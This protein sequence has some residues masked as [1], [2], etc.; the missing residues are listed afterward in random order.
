MVYPGPGGTELVLAQICTE[1]FPTQLH[2]HG[3]T[4]VILAAQY[5]MPLLVLPIV[6]ANILLF[7]R[8]NSGFQTDQRRREREL[9]RTRRMT[10]ILTLIGFI[11]AVS[12]LPF[13][14][15]VILTDVFFLFQD[16]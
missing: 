6:H 8:K 5:V 14:L 16:N 2:K 11:F 15:F 1:T 9:K 12:W 3:F 4:I 13:H 7:L 10:F